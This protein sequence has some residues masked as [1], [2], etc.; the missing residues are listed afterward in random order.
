MK[1]SIVIPTLNEAQSIEGTL[2]ALQAFRQQGVQIVLVDGGS[3]DQT[4]ALARPWVDEILS[5]PRGRSSQMNAGAQR[6]HGDVLLFLHAD[7]QLPADS[8]N[9]LSQAI[10]EGA[11]WGRFDVQISGQAWMLG[12]VSW[13]MNKRSRLTA[14]ATGDQAIFVDRVL[15][16]RVGG[17]PAQALMEDI[18]LS[19]RLKRVKKPHCLRGPAVTSGRRWETRGVWKTIFLMWRLRWLYW[20]GVTPERIA[21]KYR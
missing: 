9:Q 10:T 4:E 8:I 17:F 20:W 12:V 18:E 6:A 11:G 1:L 3:H 19:K 14:I 13:L 2:T 16:E 21:E 5:A 7:T 15:F